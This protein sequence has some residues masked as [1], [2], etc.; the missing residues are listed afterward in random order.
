MK[1]LSIILF[2]LMA[3]MTTV[4][5]QDIKIKNRTL[6]IDGNP[7]VGYCGEL[8]NS[9]S[10]SPL[11]MRETRVF[12]RLK[13]LNLNTLIGTVS[14]ELV[15]QQEGRYDFAL[16]DT[17]IANCRQRDMK[18]VVLWFGFNKNPFTTY[19]PSW[20][21]KDPKRFPRVRNEKGEDLQLPS[22]F[23]P[24]LLKTETGAFCAMMQHIRDV[25]AAQKTVI[26]VQVEN[27]PGIRNTAR[28]YSDAANK[29]F[30]SA[31]PR[32]LTSYL[33]KNAATLQPELKKA[34]EAA[35]RRTSGT[36]EQVFGK[37]IKEGKPV[38]TFLNLPEGMF[39]AYSY[40]RY[41]NELIVAGKAVYDIP[42]FTNASVFGFNMKGYSL[43]NGCSI[44]D[45]FD[46]YRAGAP[47]LDA[48]APNCYRPELDRILKVFSWKGNPLIIPESSHFAA[49]AL[50]AVGEH[51][52]L[53]SNFGI[54]SPFTPQNREDYRLLGEAYAAM[55]NMGSLITQN[56]GDS[57]NM[58]G[59]ILYPGHETQTITIGDYELSFN[60]QKTID[61]AALMAPPDMEGFAPAKKK[62]DDFQVGALVVRDGDYFYITGYGVNCDVKL[63]KGIKH[64]YCD[65]DE[66]REGR[67]VNGEFVEGRLL[68]GDERNVLL[69]GNRIGSLRVKMYYY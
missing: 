24:N 68:N 6:F 56:L 13:A 11:Y 5:A 66:I 7:F 23:S 33:K 32:Q 4:T 12:D 16:L 34:W 27:E 40:A 20:V 2:L 19:A 46:M 37:G 57:P 14:W 62:Q 22:V 61:I 15:E 43:G 3:M 59:V 38:E 55:Q 47:A 51:A 30:S 18:L 60:R 49:R 44:E 64:R 58:R 53:F 52:I 41:I 28:D 1:R 9:T 29:A 48:Q 42:M 35:G 17:L 8:H 39:T 50:Y 21:R 31:V 67:F 63:K 65:Y 69:E 26:M 45:Y 54:D 10:S 25:D 36:W